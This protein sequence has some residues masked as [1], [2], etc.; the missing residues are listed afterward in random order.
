MITHSP[1]TLLID[2]TSGP[3]GP[4][5]PPG[6]R[7]HPGRE[8]DRGP[9]G[10]AG[11]RG[12]PGGV[13]E[14]YAFHVVPASDIVIPAG[15]TALLNKW[16]TKVGQFDTKTGIFVAPASGK[17][18]I[19]ATVNL[20]SL[21]AGQMEED[22]P[23]S[24]SLQVMVGREVRFDIQ[25]TLQV[26]AKYLQVVLQI[27]TWV[28]LQKGEEMSLCLDNPTHSTLLIS[29]IPGRSFWCGWRWADF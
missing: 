21:D 15:K 8:G 19:S 11:P 2:R 9:Q 14:T 1:T 29:S 4:P 23:C 12:I 25:P 13:L 28:Q 5:G 3:T 26:K 18:Y 6:P 27:S 17:Y 20:P 22:D 16:V 24:P 10:A 7:G